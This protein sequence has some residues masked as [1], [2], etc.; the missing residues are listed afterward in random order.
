MFFEIELFVSWRLRIFYIDGIICNRVFIFFNLL[1]IFVSFVIC[2][3]INEI[4]DVEV[5]LYLK[6][7]FVWFKMYIFLVCRLYR[8]VVIE[9][10]KFF[11]Y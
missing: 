7:S 5:C 10:F 2:Y 9:K 3:G 11:F 8:W 4:I 1:L 6:Y